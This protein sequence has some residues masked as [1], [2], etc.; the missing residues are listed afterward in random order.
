ME[1]RPRVATSR[2][3]AAVRYHGPESPEAVDARRDLAAAKISA[4]IDSA[5]AAS[6]APLKPEHAAQ[7]AARLQGGAR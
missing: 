1:S 5:L 4:S 7:L 6:G 3:G 2:Y